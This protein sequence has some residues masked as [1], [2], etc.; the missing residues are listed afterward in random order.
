MV[1]GLQDAGITASFGQALKTVS[2][3]SVPAAVFSAG[4]SVALLSAA[5][6]NLPALLFGLLSIQGSGV[7][8]TLQQA[9][10][11]GA[12]VGADIGPKLT[13]IGSLATLLWLHVLHE[14]GIKVSWGQYFRV[15]VVLTFPVLMVG[16][17]ALWAV[18]H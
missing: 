6:N 2:G 16:L 1:Y 9:L 17:L 10:L 7:T 11:F 4:G 3:G 8:G 15:G 12:L 13:P 5:L 18:V 14:R